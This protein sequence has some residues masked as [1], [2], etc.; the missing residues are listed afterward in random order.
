MDNGSIDGGAGG[1]QGLKRSN[2]ASSLI[3]DYNALPYRKESPEVQ[4]ERKRIVN[5]RRHY[6]EQK[7][8]LISSSPARSSSPYPIP[9]SP[10]PSRGSSPHPVNTHNHQQRSQQQYLEQEN[11]VPANTHLL[12]HPATVTTTSTSISSHPN[13]S[14]PVHP[15]QRSASPALSHHP[16]N[17]S[18]GSIGGGQSV[19]QR[20]VSSHSARTV[21]LTD[22]VK[23]DIE[24]SRSR[25]KTRK[26]KELQEKL[27]KTFGRKKVDTMK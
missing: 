17:Q 21:N 25:S 9:L 3:I 26:E 15:P 2:S 22:A 12:G 8:T 7:Q 20:S 18:N 5:S 4:R 6:L 24:R 27:Q 10:A 1:G 14:Q 11:V 13:T 23:Y 19:S 16:H